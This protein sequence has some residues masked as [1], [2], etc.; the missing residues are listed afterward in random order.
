MA[1]SIMERRKKEEGRRKKEEGKKSNYETTNS[2][3]PIIRLRSRTSSQVPITKSQFP[4]T[5]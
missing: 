4:I 1:L 2:Q 5:N 3:V